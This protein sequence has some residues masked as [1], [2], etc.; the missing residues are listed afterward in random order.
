M[1]RLVRVEPLR[2]IQPSAAMSRGSM[3]VGEMIGVFDPHE[4][5]SNVIEASRMACGKEFR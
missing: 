5:F 3:R 4:K 2:R 1:I